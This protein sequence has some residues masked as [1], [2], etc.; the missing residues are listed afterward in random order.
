MLHI[1]AGHNF[2]GSY[3]IRVRAPSGGGQLSQRQTGRI[4][5]ELCGVSGCVCAGRYGTGPTPE[6]ADWEWGIERKS[7]QG[8]MILVPAATRGHWE[9]P[10]R[11]DKGRD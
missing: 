8:V 5:R 1:I 11:P 6:S 9:G 7:G 10:S 2:H 4:E 3:L